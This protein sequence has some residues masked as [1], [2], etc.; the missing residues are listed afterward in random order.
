MAL[1]L[2]LM[3]MLRAYVNVIIWG[4]LAM[5][6]GIN[7]CMQFD[8]QTALKIICYTATQSAPYLEDTN[9]K[10]FQSLSNHSHPPLV[11]WPSK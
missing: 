4:S 7:M 9:P 8:W 2:S 5:G 10:D 11:L 1:V 6:L 3:V